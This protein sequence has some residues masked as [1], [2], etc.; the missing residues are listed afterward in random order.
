LKKCALK[1]QY[2]KQC[3]KQDKGFVLIMFVLAVA[4]S[5]TVLFTTLSLYLYPWIEEIEQDARRA[6]AHADLISCKEIFMRNIAADFFYDEKLSK[7]GTYFMKGDTKC[8]F[9]QTSN[10]SRQDILKIYP[11]ERHQ[12]LTEKYSSQWSHARYRLIILTTQE[13]S[14]VQGN[15]YILVYSTLFNLWEIQSF[16]FAK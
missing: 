14:I 7:G 3:H 15:A 12:E 11:V 16:I 6:H 8:L 2:S 4:A 10:L 9:T 13:V 5:V 1:K